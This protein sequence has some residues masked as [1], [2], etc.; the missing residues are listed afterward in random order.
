MRVPNRDTE[1]N[2][3]MTNFSIFLN[4]LYRFKNEYINNRDD[5]VIGFFKA[6]GSTSTSTLDSTDNSIFR[7]ICAGSRSL[8]SALTSFFPK[9]PDLNGEKDYLKD[10]L[11]SS[12]IKEMYY[13]FDIDEDDK[14]DF[15][16]LCEAIAIQFENFMKYEDN[17][18]TTVKSLFEGII[19]S[20]LKAGIENANK[21]AVIAATKLFYSSVKAMESIKL[22]GSLFD[23]RVPIENYLRN[24]FD[25]FNAFNAR[26]SH[27]GKIAYRKI[28]DDFFE[29]NPNISFYLKMVSESGSLPLDLENTVTIK[30]WYSGKYKADFIVDATFNYDIEYTPEA[31]GACFKHFVPD[32]EPPVN[33]SEYLN[34]HLKGDDRCLI[35]SFR[36][37]T[38]EIHSLLRE[39]Q[40]EFNATTEFEPID[41][42]IIE[43]LKKIN[44]VQLSTVSD[45]IYYPSDHRIK[46]A[47]TMEM[48]LIEEDGRMKET[49]DDLFDFKSMKN[50]YSDSFLN[51]MVKYAAM[52]LTIL[53]MKVENNVKES[54]VS[55]VMKEDCKTEIMTELILL[56]IDEK[57]RY[58]MFPPTC[59]AKTYRRIKEI[60]ERIYE[61]KTLAFVYGQVIE[62]ATT[63][64]N[65]TDELKD[66]IAGEEYFVVIG[67][68]NKKNYQIAIPMKY[69]NAS[70][71]NIIDGSYKFCE[72]VWNHL[73][74]PYLIPESACPVLGRIYEEI[75]RVEKEGY[76][77]KYMNE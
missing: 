57:A 68:W 10:S 51:F 34:I 65:P 60:S 61:D 41:N 73:G 31:L 21:D 67:Y 75:H 74:T 8:S 19:D 23:A 71:F 22:N 45:G 59:P 2:N 24:I 4:A 3:K 29:K 77:L 62:A 69:I 43:V 46:Y 11:N 42:N 5:F 14:E 39:L 30:M 9:N 47:P 13:E 15:D 64:K 6:A 52:L 49:G 35:S 66:I 32:D 44:G 17:I 16:S 63:Y 36:I 33:F 20:K 18:N 40:K 48:F 28:R 37:I 76:T 55:K 50:Y 12:R 56:N 1:K 58:Y 53:V 38:N 26:C 27:S 54:D 70:E 72:E 7:K 25:I